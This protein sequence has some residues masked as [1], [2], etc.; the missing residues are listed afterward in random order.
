[1]QL[2][3]CSLLEPRLVGLKGSCMMFEGFEREADKRGYLQHWKVLV[4]G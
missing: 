3:T 2:I 4:V 1:M